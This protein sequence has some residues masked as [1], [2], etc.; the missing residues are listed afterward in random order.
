MGTID[1][2]GSGSAIIFSVFVR[3]SLSQLHFPRRAACVHVP[4][5][6]SALESLFGWI[7]VTMGVY[8]IVLNMGVV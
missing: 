4:V 5:S 1:C 3:N 2:I 6:C 8:Y 7:Q